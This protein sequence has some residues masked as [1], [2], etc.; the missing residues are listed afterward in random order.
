[1]AYMEHGTGNPIVLLHGVPTSSYLWRNVMQAFEGKGRLVAPDLIGMGDIDNSGPNSCIIPEHA[2]HLF[3]LL[4]ALGVTVKGNSGD[5][6]LG[7]RVRLPLGGDAQGRG[8]RHCVHGRYC[9]YLP[10]MGPLQQGT[11]RPY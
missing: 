9:H 7:V 11:P 10:D 6:R 8:E 2:R 3:A 1:M 5:P 4:E